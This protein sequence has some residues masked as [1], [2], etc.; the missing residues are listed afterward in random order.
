MWGAPWAT[1]SF[2][3]TCRPSLYPGTLDMLCKG[4]REERGRIRP[5]TH[6]GLLIPPHKKSLG[7]CG[8]S[9][10]PVP[11]P[12][13]HPQ[14]LPLSQCLGPVASFC[15]TFSGP[16][17]FERPL[18]PVTSTYFYRGVE[19]GSDSGFCFLLSEL[20]PQRPSRWQS[21]GTHCRPCPSPDSLRSLVFEAE[22]AVP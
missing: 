17:P 11:S 20:F 10:H 12:L 6:C 15:Q 16:C 22:G 1:L 21:W 5:F 13:T 8:L 18:L 14:S 4:P 7:T 19:S 3:E 9:V 2:Y